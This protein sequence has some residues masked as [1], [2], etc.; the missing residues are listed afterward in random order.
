MEA[1][2]RKTTLKSGFARRERKHRS[3]RQP[4]SPVTRSQV[5]NGRGPD[6]HAAREATNRAPLNV[7]HSR[8]QVT[9]PP[10]V[11]CFCIYQCVSHPSRFLIQNARHLSKRKP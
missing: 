3:L 4:C 11:T 9:T 1:T 7:G 5:E 10:V 6:A 2:A 8:K